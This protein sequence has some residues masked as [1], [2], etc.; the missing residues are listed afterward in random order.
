MV[1]RA[2]LQI[3]TEKT[4]TTTLQ[5]FLATNREALARQGYRYPRFCGEKNHTGLAAYALL[6]GRV[7]AI[8]DG[9]GVHTAA[10]V[11][12]MRARMQRA[13]EA[14][15]TDDAT[16][17]FC[18]EHCHS[19]LTFPEEVATL[20]EFLGQYFDDIQI[21]VYLRRQ[22]LIA[23]SLY[24]TKLKS[25][26]V[27][28]R[29][30]PQV[31]PSDPYYNYDVFLALWEA[32]FG[33]ENVH[34]RI[35]DRKSLAGGSILTD[36]VQTWRLGDFGCFASVPDLNLSIRPEAQ[37]FLRQVN[38][39][40]KAVGGRPIE[41][42]RGHLVA[43]L[44]KAYEGRGARPG[45]AVAKAFYDG[46][47]ES[48]EAVRARH[49]PQRAELFDGDFSGYPEAEDERTLSIE[50][51]AA[52][53][54][55]MQMGAQD[56][57]CRLEAEVAIR[58][59]RLLWHRDLKQAAIAA[60][61]RALSWRPHHAEAYR[62]LGE[63]LLREDRLEEAAE[64]GRAATS[65]RPTSVEYWHFL[66]IVLRKLGSVDEALAAQGR[67]LALEPGHAGAAREREQLAARLNATTPSSAV[68]QA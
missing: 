39:H 45:Q 60:L 16:S 1:R 67:A 64:A 40:L 9:F 7:D 22:D 62:T 24:S 13:A 3:G 41:T 28:D 18:S 42:V 55:K 65:H 29:L 12:P 4:G 10:D 51:F 44:E 26:G 36:F 14:E 46:F 17:I 2:I 32:E 47:A 52:M 57:I 48:N 37:E 66:G 11:A 31:E 59:G 34:V 61:R 33:P 50:G 15:L 23:L 6:P 8:R 53:A 5:N 54:A 63:F 49:F 35:F 58:E 68:H 19:R 38:P 27:T 25:G 30:L 20:R 43:R 56:D 21:S